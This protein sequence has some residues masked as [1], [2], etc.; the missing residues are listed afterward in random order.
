MEHQIKRGVSLYS[1][2]NDTFLGRMSLEDCIRECAAMGAMGIEVVGEQTFAGWP[3]RGMPE[4]G[5]AEWHR[6]MAAYGTVPVCHDFMLDYKRYKGRMMPFDEQVASVRKDIEL[7]RR[8]GAP[9]IRSLVSVEPEVLVAAAPYAEE[10]GV[11]ILLEVHAP[12]H[13]DHPWI[14]RHAEA[15]EKSGSTALGFLPDM[16]MFLHRFPRVWKERFIRNGCPRDAADF[17]EKAYED[18][19]LAEYVV[20][21]V[22]QRWGSGPQMAMVETLRHN[23]AYEPRRMLEFMPRIHNI[24]AKFYEMTEDGQE[25]S[26]P[27]DEVVAVLKQGGYR[28][29]LCSEYEGNRWIEDVQEVD[30]L[31]LVRRQ[32]QMFA[33]LLGETV[34]A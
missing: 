15:Y 23:A 25:W 28:G 30:S 29:Y 3:E 4:A 1:F 13:F 11:T 12:L 20:L 9:Y 19:R 10:A 16:G 21:D 8:L 2:Q 31:G 24:H 18:R 6:L 34:P 33:R 27:Y 26:I 17:I 7:A 22:M 32:Q 5:I 14:I